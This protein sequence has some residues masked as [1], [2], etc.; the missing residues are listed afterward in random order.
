LFGEK[1]EGENGEARDEKRGGGS[2]LSVGAGPCACPQRALAG[3][4][5]TGDRETR[6]EIRVKGRGGEGYKS[7]GERRKAKKGRKAFVEL[8]SR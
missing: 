4:S 8:L 1:S 5:E 7:K 6:D 3:R 2:R